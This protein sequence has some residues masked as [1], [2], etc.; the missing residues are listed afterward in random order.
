MEGRKRS[1]AAGVALCSCLLIA[2]QLSGQTQ[3]A[4]ATSK[5]CRCYQDCYTECRK[6]QSRY[7]CSIGC[8]QDC[9]NG[10]GYPPAETPTSA[11]N[12]ST[13]CLESFCGVSVEPSE[14]E[15]CMDSCTKGLGA[16]APRAANS[17]L[18]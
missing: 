1:G 11:A 15:A 13:I 10:G 7:V 3:P 6:T 4:A 14:E 5:F 17:S 9:I 2:V 18:I 12:C 16:H 8:F